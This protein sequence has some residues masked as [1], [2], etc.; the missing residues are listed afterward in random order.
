MYIKKSINKQSHL[1]WHVAGKISCMSLRQRSCSSLWEKVLRCLSTVWWRGCWS[2]SMMDNSLFSIL[3]STTVSKESNLRP[4]TEPAFLMIL[5]SLFVSLALM[6]L[7]QHTPQQRKWCWQQQTGERSPTSCCT[8]WRISA[9][10]G[11]R[12]IIDANIPV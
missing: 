3:L 1:W 11:N 8:R 9:S 7:P 2:L 5:S 6:L 12:D 10:S 4:S